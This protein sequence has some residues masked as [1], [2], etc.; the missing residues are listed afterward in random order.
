MSSIFDA[1]RDGDC[2]RLRA[3][4][5]EGQDVNA[6]S[7]LYG[8]T[9]LHFAADNGRADVVALLLEN[10]ADT[11]LRATGFGSAGYT[12]LHSAAS[13]VHPHCIALLLAAGS[14]ANAKTTN[15]SYTPLLMVNRGG[16]AERK[17]IACAQL[18]IQ[19]G[20][21]VDDANEY[22]DTPIWAY[23]RKGRR[24]LAKL[25]L[26]AGAV[27]PNHWPTGFSYIDWEHSESAR[28]LVDQVKARGGWREHARAHKRVLVGLVAKCKPMP[29]D[30]AGL[31]VEFWCPPGGF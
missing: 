9:P 2:A 18:L 13:S 28:R 27:I 26:R 12:P 23:V 17:Q 20:A 22:G 30:A 4:L 14:D 21:R 11:G 25:L 6:P 8:R 29:D 15:G 3:L 16:A 31:V 7:N 24:N 1:A 10:G 5:A 19:A